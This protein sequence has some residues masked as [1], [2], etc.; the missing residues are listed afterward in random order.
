MEVGITKPLEDSTIRDAAAVGDSDYQ[1]Y[2]QAMPH[3][4]AAFPQLTVDAYWDLKVPEHV[5]LH[6]WVRDQ[7]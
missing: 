6:K 4:L 7:G 5:A 1:H 3:I 2:I